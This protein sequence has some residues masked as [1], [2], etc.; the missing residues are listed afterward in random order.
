MH[1]SIGICS[2]SLV[3]IRHSPGAATSEFPL[4]IS[5][6]LSGNVSSR[7]LP[8]CLL[9]RMALTR[10]WVDSRLTAEQKWHRYDSYKCVQATPVSKTRQ[11]VLVDKQNLDV[12]TNNCK[13][14]NKQ[15]DIKW[16][17]TADGTFSNSPSLASSRICRT[18]TKMVSRVQYRTTGQR[19]HI[20]RTG[21]LV[22][23][24]KKCHSWRG[25]NHWERT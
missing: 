12:N 6:S 20:S 7:K 8:S 5:S 24:K 19:T 2:F 4:A 22:N 10:E 1:L 13:A 25:R 17:R 11:S 16:T 23:A 9:P 21:M 14:T 3:V 15:R 18:W